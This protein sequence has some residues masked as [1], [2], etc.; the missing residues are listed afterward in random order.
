MSE[1]VEIH[2]A[3]DKDLRAIFQRFGLFENMERG[4]CRCS[5]CGRNLTWDNLGV[6]VVNGGALT[7]YCELPECIADATG[8]AAKLGSGASAPPTP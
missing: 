7:S 4:A 5:K 2:A 6:F 3:N 1:T 8:L